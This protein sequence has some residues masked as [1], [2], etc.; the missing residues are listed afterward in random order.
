M[1][2]NPPFSKGGWGDFINIFVHLLIYLLLSHVTQERLNL[3]K[4]KRNQNDLSVLIK[5]I[6]IISLISGSDI[7]CVT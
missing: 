5:E 4:L 7:F 3:D 6:R 2:F 1:F